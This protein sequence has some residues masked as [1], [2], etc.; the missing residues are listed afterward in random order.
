MRFIITLLTSLLAWTAQANSR[1]PSQCKPL[2]IKDEAVSLSTSQT[3]VLMIRNRSDI[4]LWINH[5]VSDPG[6]SAGWITRLQP[7]NWS[8]LVLNQKSF[9]LSCIESKPGHEQTVPCNSV[10]TVCEWSGAAL[11]KADEM[12]SYWA[13]ENKSLEGVAAEMEQRG[14]GLPDP[15]ERAGD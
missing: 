7:G 5:P 4:D 13:S 15:L 8:A 11:P 3:R 2:A 14:F 9:K 10:L 1:L 12:G 6:A